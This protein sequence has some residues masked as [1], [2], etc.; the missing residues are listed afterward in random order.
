MRREEIRAFGELAGDAAGGLASRVQQ[1]HTG[2]ASRVWR[3]VGPAATPVRVVHDQITSRGYSAAHRLTRGVVR[4]GANALSA[5]Q[6]KQAGSIERS[7]AGRAVVGA[8]N[9]ELLNHPAIY[10]QIRR[11]MA[12]RRALPAAAA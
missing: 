3:A 8:L 11:S 4:A 9:F 2:I 7:V 12:P 6:P 1:M 5:V 10:S